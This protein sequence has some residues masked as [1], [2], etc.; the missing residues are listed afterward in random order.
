MLAII[1]EHLRRRPGMQPRDVY[2]LLYQ[3]IRGPE[4]LIT[5]PDAFQ[6]YLAAEWE[7]LDL[8][9]SDQLW[10]SIRPDDSLLRL[11]LR[12]Y[13]AQGGL[14]D[15]LVTACLETGRRLW[16]TQAELQQAWKGFSGMCRK[17]P[18]PGLALEEVETFNAWL[19]ANG[20]PA[21]HHSDRYRSLYRPAYR[22]VAADARLRGKFPS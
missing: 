15:E 9:I 1:Q 7:S 5:S 22:L 16:G 18:L 20:F 2:K 3:G 21:V 19:E 4:H 14:F 11:N 8:S 6:K 13:K 10:E 17:N 12:P